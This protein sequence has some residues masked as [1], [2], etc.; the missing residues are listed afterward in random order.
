MTERIVKLY[1]KFMRGRIE[2]KG[3][4]VSFLKEFLPFLIMIILSFIFNTELG[5]LL[6]G[7]VLIAYTFLHDYEKGEIYLFL[8][9][10][11]IGLVL[12]MTGNLA[13]G[14]RWGESSFF[15]IPL[16]L[17]LFWGYGF[18]VIRRMGNIIL[19]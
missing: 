6:I 12:E 11:I 3:K 5:I 15:S 16:W 18:V 13:L 17:P 2:M 8:F 19:K 1:V 10:I 9:G 14:Q 7:I 4:L